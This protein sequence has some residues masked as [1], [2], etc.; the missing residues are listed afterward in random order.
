MK[1][2]LAK[3]LK[4]LHKEN[5]QQ[6]IL[7]GGKTVNERYRFLF[8]QKWDNVY[9][10]DIYRVTNGGMGTLVGTALVNSTEKIC[11]METWIA[12]ENAV[13]ELKEAVL[14]ETEKLGKLF[15]KFFN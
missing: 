6:I 3:P 9:H 4:V 2:N 12:D 13:K 15:Y 5:G 11:E 1:C 14:K 8:R 7:R 10:F